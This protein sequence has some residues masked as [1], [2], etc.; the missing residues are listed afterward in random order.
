MSSVLLNEMVPLR[1]AFPNGPVI[2]TPR[3]RSSSVFCFHNGRRYLK[4]V[5][6]DCHVPRIV[7]ARTFAASIMYVSSASTTTVERLQ[8][9]FGR[10]I[11]SEQGLVP[12]STS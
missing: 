7:A 5:I 9:C 1:S 11:I 3:R 2:E 6:V 8:N 10:R 4:L 12:Y